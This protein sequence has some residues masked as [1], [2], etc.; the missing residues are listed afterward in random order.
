MKKSEA[1]FDAIGIWFESWSF[2]SKNKLTHFFLYPILISIILSMGAI[3]FII[4]VVDQLM[5]LISPYI[6]FQPLEGTFWENTLQVIS[7]LGKY[8]T[9]FL[10]YLMMFYLIARIKKYLVL[11]LMSPVMAMI[12]ERSDMILSGSDYPFNG[13]QFVRDIVR[14]LMLS[15]RNFFLELSINFFLWFCAV[16]LSFIF[17]FLSVIV[18]LLVAILSFFVGAYFFGFAVLDYTSERK[19]LTFKERTHFVRTNIGSAL[20]IGSVFSILFF[21]PYLG[22][23]IATITCTV[24]ASIIIHRS[25][26]LKTTENVIQSK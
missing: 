26:R 8:A 6:E 18:A 20:G 22:V 23:S 15:I 14:G 4:K 19:N 7:N 2:I 17:P 5:A 21:L 12:S 10:L 1:F 11:A 16:L 9:A 13:A 24:A 3:V 25:S